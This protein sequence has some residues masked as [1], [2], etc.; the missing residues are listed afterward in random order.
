MLQLILHFLAAQPFMTIF[1]VLGV[2]YLLGRVSL[3]FFSIG[4]TA[5]CASFR[6]RPSGALGPPQAV[7]RLADALGLA[8]KPTL[9][10]D[11][12]TLAF[13][14]GAGWLIGLAA[15]EVAGIPIGL[16]TM[17]GIVVAGMV[18]STL[19]SSRPGFGGPMPEPARAFL[20]GI[21][22]DLFV[23]TLGLTVAPALVNAMSDGRATLLV[24]RLSVVCATLPTVIS[25]LVGPMT[26]DGEMRERAGLRLGER[27]IREEQRAP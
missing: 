6:G 7:A 15:V 14:I 22:V 26:E 17:G 8:V 20:E 18:V 16:G 19:R 3:R 13:G 27:D 1:F 23:T 24:L 12:V 5:G 4:S 10:T 25:W 11:I 2:G 21:G 9:I